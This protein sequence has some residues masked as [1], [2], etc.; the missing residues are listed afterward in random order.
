MSGASGQTLFAVEGP[1]D[2]ASYGYRLAATGDANL[3]G[4]PDFV[5]IAWDIG[6]F[7]NRVAVLSGSTGGL[8]THIQS[9]LALASALDSGPGQFLDTTGDLDGNG[10][11]EVLVP[12]YFQE[13]IAG[14]ALVADAGSGK[15]LYYLQETA[16]PGSFPGALANA[17]DRDGDG[18]DEI[19]TSGYSNSV[20]IDT[21]RPL[22]ATTPVIPHTT[23]GAA[24]F[25]LNAGIP[26]AGAPYFLLA[27][28]TPAGGPGCG[29]MPI[30]TASLP[31]CYDLL[32]AFSI[33][34]VNI[35][36]FVDTAGH[37]DAVSGK[38]EAAFDLAGVPL[39]ASTVGVTIWFAYIAKDGS[40]AA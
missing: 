38:A 12:Y 29:G 7:T 27:S 40:E 2:L 20:T 21:V 34:L 22:V 13:I 6:T 11:R 18:L 37:L 39:P 26:H 16:Q 24:T 10:I 5:T 19:P 32:T 31:L 36:P 1:N 17:G 33:L 3:D 4:T 35:P 8:L 30:G 25:D 15:L 14:H 23:G 28:L 9:P